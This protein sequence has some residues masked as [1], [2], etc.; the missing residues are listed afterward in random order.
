MPATKD[1]NKNGLW[2]YQKVVYHPV[3]GERILLRKRGFSSKKDAEIAEAVAISEIIGYKGESKLLFEEVIK[4]YLKYKSK[5][6][7]PRTLEKLERLFDGF[8]IS[9]VKGK[10]MVKFSNRDAT[11]FYDQLLEHTESSNYRNKIVEL[12]KS[13]YTFAEMQ[14][15]LS[16]NPV[17]AFRKFKVKKQKRVFQVYSMQEFEQFISTFSEV[18]AYELSIKVFFTILYWAGVRRGECKALKWNDID[19]ELG[20]IRIDEQFIDKDPNVGRLCTDVKT[21]NSMRIIYTDKLTMEMLMK[22]YIL[23]KDINTFS[24]DSFIFLRRDESNPFADT[25]I[26]NR[27]KLHAKKA[28]IKRIRVHDFRHSFASLNY[29]LGVDPKTISTQMGHS[30]LTITLDTYVNLFDDK[31]KNRVDI[32]N[33]AKSLMNKK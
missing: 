10:D 14:Y 24:V 8:I 3:T 11:K 28:G 22:L 15:D 5:R 20:T 13:L 27:N 7:N 2:R 26:E 30:N 25:M 12:I 21:E 29:A 6:V 4:E 31:V 17:R 19:F 16:T 23:R 33:K 1:E 18:N 9:A 32:I